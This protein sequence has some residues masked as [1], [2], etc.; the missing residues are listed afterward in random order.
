MVGFT[1]SLFSVFKAGA[2]VR[3][4]SLDM[5]ILRLRSLFLRIRFF[6]LQLIGC[7]VWTSGGS[8]FD[9][10]IYVNILCVFLFI[11]EL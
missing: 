1:P 10:G 6:C 7:D 5:A 8:V 3:I 2:C 9:D 4:C 11:L